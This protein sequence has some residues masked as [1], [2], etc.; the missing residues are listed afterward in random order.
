MTLHF[1]E[2]EFKSR[3][4][5]II[6]SMKEKNLDALL[7]FRQESMYWLTG[8]DTFGYVFFQCLVFTLEGNKILLTRAADLRQAQNT[9]NIKDIR[10]WVDRDNNN[11]AEELK[12]ILVE[13]NL[14]NKN[15]GVEYETYGLTGKNAMMLNASLNNFAKLHDESFLVSKHRLVKSDHEIKYVKKAAELADKALEKAWELSH[16]RADES[17]ILSAMQGAIFSGGGDYPGNEFIIGS[18]PDALLCRYFSG[19]RKLDPIDQLTLEFA[20]VY[21]HYHSALMRTIPIGKAKKEH[22]ELHEI[23]LEALAACEDKLKVGNTVGDVFEQHRFVIDKTKFK[24]ARLN[25]CGY[26]LGATFAPSWMDWP[27]LYENNPVLIQKN[28]VFFIHMIL[29]HSETQTAMNLGETY[30]VSK[31]G[32]ERLG[33]LKLD[34]VVG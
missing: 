23:C 33:K 34:L 5:K 14:E 31:T 15:L 3:K 21:R 11:P 10:I 2:K 26:S 25:A 30:I 4:N 6:E 29:M 16:P 18:G 24:S 7:L 8:Y 32:C 22:L 12:S 17:D 20:G 27:M 13:L 9:S 28:H 1:T 19:R